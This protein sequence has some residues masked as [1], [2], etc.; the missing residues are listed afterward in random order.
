MNDSHSFKK[1]CKK[2]IELGIRLRGY[3]NQAKTIVSLV[4]IIQAVEVSAE[5]D[6]RAPIGVPICTIYTVSS[7]H[8]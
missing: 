8:I 2:V 5:Q 6:N 7:L 3:H 4:L 1:S